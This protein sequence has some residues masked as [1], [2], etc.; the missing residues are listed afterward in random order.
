MQSV[1][2]SL[3]CWGKTGRVFC[4]GGVDRGA[5][6]PSRTSMPPLLRQYAALTAIGLAAAAPDAPAAVRLVPA[7]E[8]SAAQQGRAAGHQQPQSATGGGMTFMSM[9]ASGDHRHTGDRNASEHQLQHGWVT[10]IQ[11]VAGNCNYGLPPSQQQHPDPCPSDAALLELIERS[12][13]A[14]TTPFMYTELP[15]C[16]G[17]GTGVWKRIAFCPTARGGKGDYCGSF[18]AHCG[19]TSCGLP[20][21]QQF[22]GGGSLDKNWRTNLLAIAAGL[23]PLVDS[24]KIGAV[25]LGDELVDFGVSLENITSVANLLRKEL[26]TKVKLILN[27]ACGMFG[28]AGWPTIPAALDYISCDV[29]NVTDGRGEAE[30]IIDY[31]EH[32]LPKLR[33][34]ANCNINA[35]FWEFSSESAE[36]IWN[37]P[38]KTMIF[39]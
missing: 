39:H 15:D 8:E 33:G 24:G 6:L 4:A 26:G 13:E 3:A 31:Y 7:L 30:Q 10:H 36:T 25:A 35:N 23:R 17:C 27:D 34:T 32:F 20:A 2:K 19:G 29:Y 5:G 37:F 9:M 12:E 1:A 18:A 11:V 14:W 38:L 16:G 22:C 28:P 21:C